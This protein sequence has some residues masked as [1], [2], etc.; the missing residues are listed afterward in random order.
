MSP[1]P[2]AKRSFCDENVALQIRD[3]GG[4]S[5]SAWDVTEHGPLVEMEAHLVW[6]SPSGSLVDVSP[7]LVGALRHFIFPSERK[8]QRPFPGNII[9][10]LSSDPRIKETAHY[11]TMAHAVFA[12][13]KAVGSFAFTDAAIKMWVHD[14][15]REGNFTEDAATLE[16]TCRAIVRAWTRGSH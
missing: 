3:H 6:R 15:L 11:L 14:F 16:A 12:K 1:H 13:H 9:V 5:F 2:A 4:E 7:S 8:F 10:S